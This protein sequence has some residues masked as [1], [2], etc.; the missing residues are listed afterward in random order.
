MIDNMEYPFYHLDGTGQI[1]HLDTILQFEKLKVVQWQP[2]AGKEDL[3]QWYE[4]IKKIIDNKKSVQLYSRVEEVKP[5]VE[6]LGSA[7]GVLCILT[8]AT[9]ENLNEGV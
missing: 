9:E 7:K 6:Y 1:P 3:K 5:L 8:N 2:G 4:L